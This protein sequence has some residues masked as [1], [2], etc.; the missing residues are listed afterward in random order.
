MPL[1][2][3]PDSPHIT[4]VVD[5]ARRLIRVAR[6]SIPL[7]GEADVDAMVRRARAELDRAG[8]R[9]NVLLIDLRVALLSD[10][11]NY[12]AA[13]RK[14]RAEIT[15][16]FARSAFLVTTSVGRIQV[17]R[18]LREEHIDAPVF[19]DEAEALRSLGVTR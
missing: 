15:R 17:G 14:L 11:T 10:E 3:S 4:V 13:M 7:T 5:A 9:S 8:R 19:A 1:P 2:S 18:F 16:G 12:A 6:T